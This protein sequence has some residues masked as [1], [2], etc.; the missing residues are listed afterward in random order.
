MGREGPARLCALSPTWPGLSRPSTPRRLRNEPAAGARS[1]T[2]GAP[3][4]VDGRDKPGHDALG[5]PRISAQG[6]PYQRPTATKEHGM[7]R[8][9]ITGSSD[10]LG[11]M[12]ASFSPIRDTSRPA[13]AQRRARGGRKGRYPRP[14]RSSS[15][16]SRPSRPPRTS[17]GRSMRSAVSTRSFTT[18]R[19][20]SRKVIASPPTACRMSSPSTRSRPTS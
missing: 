5:H 2:P 14:K 11:L 17:R 3:K 10:G 6:N 12:A 16:I 4:P 18:P 20:A 9:F 7:A 15:A 8:V 19:S 13:R 1:P